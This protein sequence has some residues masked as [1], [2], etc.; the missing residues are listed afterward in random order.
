MSLSVRP[1]DP[2]L[3][4]LSCTRYICLSKVFRE[5]SDMAETGQD[6]NL[7]TISLQASCVCLP[8]FP[9]TW[10]L[11]QHSLDS[12]VEAG[13]NWA[14]F[15]AQ[16]C[17]HAPTPK[18][19]ECSPRGPPVRNLLCPA[20]EWIGTFH[21]CHGLVSCPSENTKSPLLRQP[22]IQLLRILD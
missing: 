22:P 1:E 19:P 18:E 16:Y 13:R 6:T 12:P 15:R 5:Q 11:P 3:K 7:Q 21:K 9:Q 4:F 14:G 17:S 8:P 10:L 2:Y 20:V